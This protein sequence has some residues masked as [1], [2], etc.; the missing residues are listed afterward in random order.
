MGIAELL[1]ERGADPNVTCQG[2]ATPLSEAARTSGNLRLVDLLLEHG[3]DVGAGDGHVFASA[4]FG[5]LKIL[6]RL[7]EQP[8]TDA[9]RD[10]HLGIALQRAAHW[11]LLEVVAW[12][13]DQGASPN[14]QGGRY[15][16]V[17]S[18]AVSNRHVIQSSTINDRKLTVDLLL[19]HGADPNPSPLHNQPPHHDPDLKAPTHAPPLV[20]ALTNRAAGLARTLLEAGADPN[21]QGGSPPTALQ[22][23][24]FY[25]PSMVGPLLAAGADAAAVTA[26]GPYGT[27]LHAAAYG[28]DVAGITALLAAG[29]DVHAVA[30][31]YG[32]PLHA[33]AKRE[34]TKSGW[35]AGRDSLR[36]VRVLVEAG[37]DPH[38]RAGKYDTVA[39]V[40]AKSG[41]L[42]VLQWLVEEMGVDVDLRG[43]R[44]G[45]VREAAVRK[46][47]WG[48]VTYLER[49]FGPFRWSG[50]YQSPRYWKDFTV[51]WETE[52][53]GEE[54]TGGR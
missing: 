37:A 50:K 13:L 36:A 41:N 21:L 12:L 53:A 4:I 8:T 5:G 6:T 11:A 30:G 51:V 54:T 45:S 19:S 26:T 16:C 20:A 31:K 46:G 35:T 44:Y 7:F 43:G 28:H 38:A 29:A 3:A 49:R 15:G 39:Q 34:T 10:R 14:Y 9:A 47:R 18:A 42:E 33:A 25:T 32:T 24:A 2:S 23:A 22:A 48:V 1:L 17:L 40:A 52:K 27:A